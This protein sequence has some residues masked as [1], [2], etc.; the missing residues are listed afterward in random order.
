MELSGIIQ[1]T[2]AQYNNSNADSQLA[3]KSIAVQ[4]AKKSDIVREP[5][6]IGQVEQ[7]DF[8][9]ADERRFNA[10]RKTVE[11]ETVAGSFLLSDSRFTIFKD[12]KAG[13]YITRF[14][15]MVNGAVTYVPE[16]DILKLAGANEA[17]FEVNA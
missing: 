5:V 4:V 2:V 9:K 11:R 10:I 6:K 12:S 1:K 7:L 13:Q 8:K 17:Y 15:N 14:T 16:P 3:A